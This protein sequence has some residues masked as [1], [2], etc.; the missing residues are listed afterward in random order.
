V[1]GLERRR[2]RSIERALGESASET[3]SA[4]RSVGGEALSR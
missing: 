1:R 4:L 2:M 3:D